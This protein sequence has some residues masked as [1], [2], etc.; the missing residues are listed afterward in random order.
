MKDG[1]ATQEEMLDLIAG[2]P[3]A[4]VAEHLFRCPTCWSSACESLGRLDSGSAVPRESLALREPR[5]AALLERYRLEQRKLED[6]LAA[7]SA[8]AQVRSMTRKKRKEYV[9][10][11]KPYHTAPGVLGLL[12]EARAANV[13]YDGEEWADLAIVACYQILTGISEAERGDLLAECYAELAGARRRS[14]RW[15]L[16]RE[17]LRQGREHHNKGT[18]S[19]SVEGHLLMVEG[20][21]EGDLGELDRAEQLLEAAS[22]KF[23]QAEIPRLAA[24]AIT[25][26][27]YVVLDVSPD[28]TIGFLCRAETL[29]PF[30]DKRLSM[31]AESIRVD[32]LITLGRSRE[33]LRRFEQLTSVYEQFGDPFVQLR[34]HFTAGRLLESIGRFDE[35]DALFFDVISADLEQRSNKSFFLDLL[36]CLD[37]YVRRGDLSGALAVCDRALSTISTLELDEAS[38]RQMADLWNGLNKQLQ[39]GAATV[40]IILQAKQ[41]IKTRWRTVGGDALLIKESAV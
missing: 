32:A 6:W 27:A 22:E 28:R 18:G 14:A 8:V 2:E 7:Q 15:K 26:I 11:T 20:C 41:F 19:A 4:A 9:A 40:Q 34:R 13:P 23:L 30:S 16:A 31:F 25:Q 1:H 29:M 3:T 24:K 39:A 5:R 10:R 35:A 38:E 36:Y 33:A 21:I 12:E 17:A 37:S